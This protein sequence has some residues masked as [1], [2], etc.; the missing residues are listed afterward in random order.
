MAVNANMTFNNYQRKHKKSWWSF[1]HQDFQYKIK[2][3]LS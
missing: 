3:L 1:D 2:S